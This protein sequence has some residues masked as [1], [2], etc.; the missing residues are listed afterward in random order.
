MTTNCNCFLKVEEWA[1]DDSIGYWYAV[2][3]CETC[4]YYWEGPDY[5]KSNPN[6][7]P[8]DGKIGN[9]FFRIQDSYDP[10]EREYFH[11]FCYDEQNRYGAPVKLKEV[12]DI[13]Q[14][15]ELNKY[16]HSAIRVIDPTEDAITLEVING[17]YVFPEEWKR[18]NE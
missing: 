6:I 17:K 13:Y 12:E 8:T 14:F 5:S 16:S 18:F 11:I 7:H 15:C 1:Y 4:G 3:S 10:K 9:K 2:R